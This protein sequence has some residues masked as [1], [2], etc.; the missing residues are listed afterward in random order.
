MSGERPRLGSRWVRLKKDLPG[1]APCCIL[2]QLQLPGS[3]IKKRGVAICIHRAK[4]GVTMA[5]TT[6]EERIQ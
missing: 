4:F 2:L 5:T 1:W 3:A 6:Q